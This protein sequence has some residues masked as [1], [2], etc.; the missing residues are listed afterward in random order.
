MEGAGLFIVRCV[1]LIF[2]IICIAL[3]GNVINNNIDGH[4]SAINYA[5]FAAII[6][7]V[8][9]LWGM[10]ATFLSVLTEG[11]FAYGLLAFDVLAV[12]FVFVAAIV[13][14]AKLKAVNCGGDL[15]VE[16]RG[17]NWIGFGSVD[18]EQRCRELQ[19][20][21]AFLWFLFAALV[22]ALLMTLVNFRRSGRSSGGSSA[23]HMS[24]VRV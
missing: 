4:M 18:D 1:Q 8:A 11:I 12:I 6:A 19:A 21:T 17:A 9:C 3:F 15:T 20:G 22:V 16:R 23:P 2:I 10:I 13:I 24:Q 5:L 14:P 7:W